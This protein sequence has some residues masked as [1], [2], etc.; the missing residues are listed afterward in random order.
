MRSDRGLRRLAVSFLAATL[1]V[2]SGCGRGESAAIVAHDDVEVVDGL[3][4]YT[5]IFRSRHPLVDRDWRHTP[6]PE[7]AVGGGADAAQRPGGTARRGGDA[8]GAGIPYVTLAAS[9]D[10]RVDSATSH[11]VFQPLLLAHERRANGVADTAAASGSAAGTAGSYWTTPAGGESTVAASAGRPPGAS[12]PPADAGPGA[13]DSASTAAGDLTLRLSTGAASGQP[14]TAA[15]PPTRLKLPVG[16]LGAPAPLDDG[17]S[18]NDPAA[19][20]E[21]EVVDLVSGPIEAVAGRALTVHTEGG[22]RAVVLA[23]DLSIEGEVSGSTADLRAG[24][25]AAVVQR[26]GGPAEIVRVFR[27]GPGAP[28]PGSVPLVGARQGQIAT[29]GT[30]VSR[31]FDGL[32]LRMSGTARSVPVPNDVPVYLPAPTTAGA[33]VPGTSIVASGSRASNGELT[34]TD[35]RIVSDLPVAR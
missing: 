6:A 19:S 13:G 22:P 12:A 33:L 27:P 35:V 21:S 5:P 20:A 23:D 1:I 32:T 34:A 9:D 3:E 2:A 29:F 11:Q 28:T 17:A 15:T 7:V 8:A 24:M 31:T 25:L 4:A 26:P 16:L 14:A 18:R 30:V 10:P